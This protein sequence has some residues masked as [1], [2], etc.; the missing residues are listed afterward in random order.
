MPTIV[1]GV[2]GVDVH[3]IGNWVLRRSLEQAGFQIIA[4]GTQVSQEEFIQ[5]AIETDADAIL[6]SSIYGQAY[7]DCE[8]LKD[9]CTEAGL[10]RILLYIGGN[11]TIG[12]EPWDDI[13]KRFK[14]IG[15]NRVYPPDTMPSVAIKD[16]T[17]DLGAK[18]STRRTRKAKV[19]QPK[20][21]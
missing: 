14:D 18:K 15:F 7:L 9:K 5:A 6:V 10:E 19:S 4:L 21:A 1:T 20:Q 11:L 2:I 17:E 13:E 3:A 8:G 12:R 16:L